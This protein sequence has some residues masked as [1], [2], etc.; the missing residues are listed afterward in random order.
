M[1]EVPLPG[2]P[3][4][5]PRQRRPTAVPGMRA[6]RIKGS[7]KRQLCDR[8][9]ELI[10]QLGQA[11]APYPRHA[12]WSV[13]GDGWRVRLCEQHKEERFTR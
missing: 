11:G 8:C 7:G 6:T 12:R 3:E 2:M 9:C 13:T 10:H 4:P 1:N 5:A